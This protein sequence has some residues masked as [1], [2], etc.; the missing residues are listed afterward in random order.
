MGIYGEDAGEGKGRNYCKD[1]GCNQGILAPGWRSDAVE[2]SYLV[3]PLEALSKAFDT[4]ASSLENRPEITS[5]L[6]NSNLKSISSSAAE[7]DLCLVFISSDAGEG[8][9]QDLGVRGGRNDLFVQK[10]GDKLVSTVT[11][12][13][14][15]T[16]VVIHAVGAVVVERWILSLVA[17]WARSAPG[18]T[19]GVRDTC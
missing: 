11:A 4:E 10:D 17:L 16:I 9:L 5:I 13:C 6:S 18:Y 15:N 12:N 19:R 7:Q 1:R 3:T 14:A 2:F 8:Y